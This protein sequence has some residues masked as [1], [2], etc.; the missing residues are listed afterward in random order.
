MAV[1][2]VSHQFLVEPGLTHNQLRELDAGSRND[3]IPAEALDDAMQNTAP[4]KCADT[5]K[6]IKSFNHHHYQNPEVSMPVIL[7]AFSPIRQ[8]VVRNAEGQGAIS[9]TTAKRHMFIN[10]E[11]F[12][13]LGFCGNLDDFQSQM[14]SRW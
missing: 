4:A 5:L 9:A 3:A 10:E 14:V 1:L 11:L 13:F 2:G 8:R 12:Q 6:S 7:R